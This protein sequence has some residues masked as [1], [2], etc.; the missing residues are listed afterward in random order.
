MFTFVWW[1][2]TLEAAA[3]FFLI[4]KW[5]PRGRYDSLTIVIALFC[6][7]CMVLLIRILSVSGEYGT[8]AY[9]GCWPNSW[10]LIALAAPFFAGLLTLAVMACFADRIPLWLRCL[11]P[12]AVYLVGT[13]LLV[14]VWDRW[15]LPFFA[16]P[17]PW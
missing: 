4:P 12:T 1:R 5:R 17:P 10:D 15:L 11:S 3:G 6:A 9:P 16:G 8:C 14:L 13:V 2:S 7:L